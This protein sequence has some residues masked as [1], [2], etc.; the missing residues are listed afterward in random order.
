MSFAMMEIN[1]KDGGMGWMAYFNPESLKV[2]LTNNLGGEENSNQ[3]TQPAK[4]KLEATLIFDSTDMGMDV[5]GGFIIGTQAL[6]E[7]A[8]TNPEHNNAPPVLE[9]VWGN[10]KFEGVIESFNETLDF[11]SGEGVPLRSTVQLTM[12]GVVEE[13]RAKLDT[14][15]NDDIEIEVNSISDSALGTTEIAQR[16]GAASG[17][18][19]AAR[20]IAAENGS[21][22]MRFPGG[23]PGE[24]EAA[25]PADDKKKEEKDKAKSGGGGGGGGGLAVKGGVE[26]KAAAGFSLGMSAGASVGF[27]F[28][29][30]A[31]GGVGL[32]V[33]GGIGAGIGGGISAGAG[34]GF[35]ASAGAGFGAGGGAGIGIGAGAGAG[36]G[37]GASAG[38]SFGATAGT[39]FGAGAGAGASFESSFGAGSGFSSTSTAGFAAGGAFG[40]SAGDGGSAMFAYSESTTTGFGGSTV[41]TSTSSSWTPSGGWDEHSSTIYGGSSSSALAGLS[42]SEGAFAGL[43]TAGTGPQFQTYSTSKL[44]AP[45]APP[46]PGPDASFDATGRMVSSGGGVRATASA[47][48]SV[49]ML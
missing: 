31:G 22:S 10:F 47:S 35:G 29:A 27:G 48:A 24:S 42:A 16:V 13:G 46:Q 11:W 23:E 17:D 19:S 5:R 33:G 4:P 8:L 18:T 25:S 3:A 45:A 7:M 21:E 30:A 20:D 41:S 28:G 49:R 43:S 2:S 36:V 9:L 34:I 14:L 1:E 37:F 39:S 26:L 15:V 12:Q 6:K 40:G 44:M 32:G 38:S